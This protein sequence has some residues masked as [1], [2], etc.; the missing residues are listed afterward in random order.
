MKTIILP[1]RGGILLARIKANNNRYTIGLRDAAY[2]C[3]Y[4]SVSGFLHFIKRWEELGLL[5][6]EREKYQSNTYRITQD[7]NILKQ[8]KIIKR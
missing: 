6:V 3:G 5:I 8:Y 1:K 7:E 4:A 2:L